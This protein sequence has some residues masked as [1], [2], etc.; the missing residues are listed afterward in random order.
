LRKS[1]KLSEIRLYR[2]KN[3]QK[4]Y[5]LPKETENCPE[6]AETSSN[7]MEITETSQ[8]R[9]VTGQNVSAIIET[10]RNEL[11]QAEMC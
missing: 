6:P 7:M 3:I 4:R 2:L 10:N 8:K 11:P 9:V 1:T 5:E